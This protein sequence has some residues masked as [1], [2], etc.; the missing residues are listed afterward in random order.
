MESLCNFNYQNPNVSVQA[1]HFLLARSWYTC[2]QDVESHVIFKMLHNKE[3]LQLHVI[4]IKVPYYTQNIF[5]L[6]T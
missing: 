5:F 2:A 6:I 4:F 3:S 1:M